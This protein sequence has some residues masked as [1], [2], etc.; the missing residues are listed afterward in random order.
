M[1]IKAKAKD[2]FE[3]RTE[4][5][6]TIKKWNSVPGHQILSD[7]SGNIGAMVAS[8]SPIRR[9]WYPHIG[10]NVIDGSTT[11]HDWEGITDIKN[12]PFVINPEKG[13]VVAANNRIVPDNSKFDFGAESIS[14]SRGLRI[15]EL[16][17]K[18]IQEGKK[19][20]VNDMLEM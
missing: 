3:Y 4:F 17:E 9:N 10:M 7:S 8:P 13:Y 1:R 16:I 11:K 5:Q 20:E 2:L 18:G 19:F 12:L 15:R 6:S 14:T